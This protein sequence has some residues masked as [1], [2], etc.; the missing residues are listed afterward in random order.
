MTKKKEHPFKNHKM[1]LPMRLFFS[2][3][4]LLFKLLGVVSPPLAGRL[5]LRYFM[6][7][8]RFRTPRKEKALRESAKLTFVT[9]RDRKISVRAWGDDDAPTVLLSHG[10]GGRCSQFHAFIP[11]L[12]D[13]GYRVVGFDVPGHG[14]SEGKQTNMMDVATVISEISKQ[15]KPFEA[16]L[17]HSFGTG[18]ALL[19]IDKFN[20]KTKKVILIGCFPDVIWITNLFGEVFD[21]S[22]SNLE[23]MH[24]VALK[25]FKTTYGISWNWKDVS[26]LETIKSFKGE[27]FLIHD[28]NDHEVPYEQGK[29]LHDATP[30]AKIMTTSGFGHRKILM[31]KKVV[32]AVIEFIQQGK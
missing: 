22:K 1:P 9:V 19:S 27:I 21:L 11:P 29:R 16:I 10:W 7:P 26:P 17:G 28:E 20:V 2:T 13:A 32:N 23:A 14:D 31:S 15:E 3:N 30:H 18:T 12:I 25:K 5:A 24:Q 4:T 6:T 8:T